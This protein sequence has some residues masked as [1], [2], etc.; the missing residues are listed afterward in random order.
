[1]VKHFHLRSSMRRRAPLIS[2]IITWATVA[3]DRPDRLGWKDYRFAALIVVMFAFMGLREYRDEMDRRR[4]A[5]RIEAQERGVVTPETRSA[6]LP[7]P[8]RHRRFPGVVARVSPA[9]SPG[10]LHGTH[11]SFRSRRRRRAPHAELGSAPLPTRIGPGSGSRIH[12]APRWTGP[13]RALEPST[14]AVP[15]RVSIQWRSRPGVAQL[16]Q[17]ALVVG[18]HP[19]EVELSG[20]PAE[21][22]RRCERGEVVER[23][24]HE[25]R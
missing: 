9:S 3:V 20:E 4:A 22:Q 16:R 25:R 18:T 5:Q 12:G 13:R 11:L 8:L 7:L 2:Q 19:L 23:G 6:R 14:G 17:D 10:R 24:W 21:A 15:E 1:M